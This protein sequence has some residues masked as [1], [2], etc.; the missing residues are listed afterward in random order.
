[1]YGNEG[2]QYTFNNQY[3]SSASPLFNNRAILITTEMLPNFDV[4]FINSDGLIK[5]ARYSIS[6]QLCTSW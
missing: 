6:C 1:M 4:F 2:L 3:N 5:C